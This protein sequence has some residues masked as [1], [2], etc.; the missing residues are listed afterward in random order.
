IAQVARRLAKPVRVGGYDLP[1]DVVVFPSIY[2]VQRTPSVYP[3]PE[4]FRPERFLDGNPPPA[5][6]IPFGGGIRRCL[7]AALAMAEAQAV[8]KAVL[9][10]VDIEPVG[11]PEFS[12]TRNVTTVPG[13]GARLV[14]RP[15]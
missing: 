7:G 8:L 2:L 14:S 10:R 3:S 5:T 15:R 4:E 9:A 11:R 13:R 12:R 6:W 1:A